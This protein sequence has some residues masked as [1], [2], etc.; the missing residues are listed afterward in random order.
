MLITSLTNTASVYFG[1]SNKLCPIYYVGTDKKEIA[2]TFDAA[3]GAD[4]TEKIIDELRNYNVSA[5]FFLCQT[6][7]DKYPE[8]V[9]KIDAS[10]HEIGTH[11]ATH[12]D[13]KKLSAQS[14]NYELSA[15]KTAIEK[16]I[17]KTV[18]LFRPPFG[19]YSNTL[20][21]TAQNLGLYT[22]QWD[23]DSLD[24]QGLSAAQIF[25]RVTARIKNGSIILMHNDA[26]N[27]VEA[28]RLAVDYLQKTGY[29][30]KPVGDLIYKDNFKVDH[31][32]KQI[33]TA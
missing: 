20:I 24:W 12:P 2:I 28:V 7:T 6:W 15:S 3:W 17:N 26:D 19:S 1:I 11:S 10:G 33:H 8:M 16:I 21:E 32:G 30:F 5:T 4:K 13:M 9:K 29:T 27:V 14:I 25:K 18:Q 22:I 31:T 23:V